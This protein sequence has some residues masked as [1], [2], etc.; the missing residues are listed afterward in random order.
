L[1]VPPGQRAT[2]R[3]KN[4]RRKAR[5]NGEFEAGLFSEKRSASRRKGKKKR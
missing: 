2:L 5:D 4:K 1:T 3:K